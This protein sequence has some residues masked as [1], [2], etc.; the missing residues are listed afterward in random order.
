MWPR[1][2][3]A[4]KVFLWCKEENMLINDEV[5][6]VMDD[7]NIQYCEDCRNKYD[8]STYDFVINSYGQ[9]VCGAC[10]DYME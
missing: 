10:A 7:Q 5:H 1:L 8:T 2:V 4:G 6:A 9:Y 3:G